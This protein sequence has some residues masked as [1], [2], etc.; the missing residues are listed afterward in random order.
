MSRL[1]AVR[2]AVGVGA[3]PGRRDAVLAVGLDGS[4]C[5]R[6]ETRDSCRRERHRVALA[7]RLARSG[8]CASRAARAIPPPRL[9]W[10]TEW[11][12][13]E[14]ATRNI[15]VQR[16]VNPVRWR[17]TPAM[18]DR[19]RRRVPEDHAI[20][21]TSPGAARCH[22]DARYRLAAGGGVRRASPRLRAA[23]PSVRPGDVGPGDA[24]SHPHPFD[25]DRHPIRSCETHDEVP[26]G[27]TGRSVW[28]DAQ[29]RLGRVRPDCACGVCVPSRA[30]P[31]HGGG[32]A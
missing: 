27:C 8:S 18:V 15:A 1:L 6:R 2:H 4:A 28:C 31:D 32:S 24:T 25:S 7:D 11:V 14:M 12:S 23:G 3:T 30:R 19:R 21:T 20:L 9:R 29:H 17:A 13:M 26:L 16:R 5:L 10:V 22:R